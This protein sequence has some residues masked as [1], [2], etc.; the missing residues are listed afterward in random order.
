MEKYASIKFRSDYFST[1]KVD[2]R[3]TI[4]WRPIFGEVVNHCS[5][6]WT[7]ECGS[8]V[9]MIVCVTESNIKVC[10]IIVRVN[11]MTLSVLS[12]LKRMV[13]LIW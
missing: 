11:E 7:E 2:K 8:D 6:A 4:F 10:S 12:R 13:C 1:D 3:S 5:I 9:T